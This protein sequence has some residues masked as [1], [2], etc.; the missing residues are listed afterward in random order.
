VSQ[1]VTVRYDGV[2][3]Q[4]EGSSSGVLGAYTV[5]GGAQSFPSGSPQVTFT[6]T[7]G[8]SPS[9]EDGMAFAVT[10]ASPDLNRQKFLYFGPSDAAFNG[11]RSKLS[12]AAGV[13]VTLR[14][15]SGEPTLVDRA[16]SGSYTFVS[17]GS[18]VMENAV[19]QNMDADGFQLSGAGGVSLAS[20]TF[21]NIAAA[22]GAYV[23]ARSLTSQ[24]TFY[25]LTFNDAPARA[26]HSIRVTGGDGGMFWRI[27]TF[28]GPRSG[29]ASDVDPNRRV[30]W[31]DGTAPDAPS[32]LTA[33]PGSSPAQAALSWTSPGDDGPTGT[34]QGG[35]FRVF[36][37]TDTSTRDGAAPGQAQ[38]VIS[39]TAAAGSAQAATVSVPLPGATYYFRLW[40]LD[41]FANASSGADV[42]GV[43]SGNIGDLT[44][45]TVSLSAGSRSVGVLPAQALTITF[46]KAM[47]PSTVPGAVSLRR[48][49]DRLANAVDEA[50]TVTVTS[51]PDGTTYTASSTAPLPGNSLF[52]LA[53]STDPADLLGLTPGASTTL[54]FTTL[55]DRSVRNVVSD[56]AGG[57]LHRGANAGARRLRPDGVAV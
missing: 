49:K 46:S 41:E 25:N 9:A 12:A 40:A 54:R 8:P 51:A 27:A 15:T 29:D 11:G 16:V 42:S 34:I 30:Y 33:A 56:G 6:F 44:P 22:G 21:D 55:M 47:N 45:P 37:S 5:G 23:T 39:T 13:S 50:W 14:G 35:A 3:W 2:T 31:A 10:A 1:I 48:L 52:A 57:D 38:V 26:P 53:V 19:A 17:S 4:V 43:A 7:P 24:A 36:Y 20:A 28:A 32:N 18:F